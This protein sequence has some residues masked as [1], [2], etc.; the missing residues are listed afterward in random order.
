MKTLKDE[1]KEFQKEVK[2]LKNEPEKAMEVQKRAMQ[3]NMKYMG[4]SMRSTLFTFIPIIIIFGWM[5]SHIAYEA[6][7]PSQ[8]F[9]TTLLLNNDVKGEIELIE[10]EG[11]TVKSE[12]PK[13][14]EDGKA[15]WLLEAERG[16]YLLE[17]KFQ[18]RSY[19][20]ELL[21]TEQQGYSKVSKKVSD[22]FV[23]T[24]N[25]DNNPMKVLNLFGWKVGWLGTYIIFSLIFSMTLRKIV[26]VY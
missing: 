13:T 26:K 10:S 16:E 18:G 25:I 12:N 3:T 2:E 8:E 1:M 11:I 19:T 7:N 24:I 6:I 14:I 20:K 23:K 9:T 22:G 15:I 5:N 21:I 4:H 17:Y